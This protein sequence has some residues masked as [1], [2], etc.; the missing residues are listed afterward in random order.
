VVGVLIAA[1]VMLLVVG[2]VNHSQH[3]YRGAC[4]TYG[5]PAAKLPERFIF[6]RLFGR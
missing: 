6:H 3:W 5:E 2:I 1:P 4:R